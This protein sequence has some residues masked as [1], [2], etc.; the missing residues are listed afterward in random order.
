MLKLGPP[1]ILTR[2]GKTIAQRPRGL[3]FAFSVIGLVLFLVLS[4]PVIDRSSKRLAKALGVSLPQPVT[5]EAKAKG[6]VF[7]VNHK[8]ATGAAYSAFFNLG[9]SKANFISHSSRQ[10]QARGTN[11]AH[12]YW[13][14]W[15]KDDFSFTGAYELFSKLVSEKV[16]GVTLEPMQI[17]AKTYQI[18]VLLDGTEIHKIIFSKT[19]VEAES[20]AGAIAMTDLKLKIPKVR[21]KGPAKIAIII[22]DIGY[23]QEVELQF[24]T[25]PA[26]LTFAVMPF[27]PQG[28]YFA[29]E[30]HR[31]GHEVMLH[32]PM[33]PKAYPE[34]TPGKGGLLLRMGRAEILQT[35][36]MS[37]DRVPFIKGVN[38]HMG[39]AFTSDAEKMAI[40]LSKLKDRGLYFVDSRTAGSAK[41]F[42]VAKAIGIP[43]AARNVFLDH[44]P[45]PDHIARQFDLMVEYA[46]RQG[47]A[48]AI[49]HPHTATLDVLRAKLPELRKK[50]IVIVP[51][52]SLVR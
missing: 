3:V 28:E 7:A 48:I 40:V 46:L 35:L 47:S 26:N 2:L 9:L 38:N 29:Q 45:R 52:S 39:S 44:D 43:T 50:N 25:L 42:E 18:A 4:T 36:A 14:L 31:L 49:G 37:I 17:D 23:R 33:Q 12:I 34:V 21:F 15:V 32:L 10:K 6:A 19:G 8:D 20:D 5:A 1:T 16:R 27:S 11:F 22:D 41:G 24:L 51:P 30:A 13:E